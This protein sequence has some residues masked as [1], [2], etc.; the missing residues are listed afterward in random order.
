MD[1]KEKA[2]FKTSPKASQKQLHKD[3][4]IHDEKSDVK[5]QTGKSESCSQV[6]TDCISR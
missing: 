6:P 4:L 1:K 5:F 2:P 3:A